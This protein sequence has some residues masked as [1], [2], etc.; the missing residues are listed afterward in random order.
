MDQ[1]TASAP[2]LMLVPVMNIGP[3]RMGVHDGL[4]MVFMGMRIYAALLVSMVMMHVLMVVVVSMAHGLV[5]MGM[6]M[7]VV[8][9]D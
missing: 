4:V 3:M 5:R 1:A 9:E 7:L 6:G 8:K 2:S